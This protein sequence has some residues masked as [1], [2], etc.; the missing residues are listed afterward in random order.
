MK[1]LSPAAWASEALDFSN[2]EDQ[3]YQKFSQ[4]KLQ[5]I[6]TEI[7]SERYRI[8]FHFYQQI[9]IF[10][11][12]SHFL[13]SLC[14]K[15]QGFSVI[16]VFL[17]TFTEL[18]VQQV[19]VLCSKL[20]QVTVLPPVIAKMNMTNFLSCTMYA[21]CYCVPTARP[22]MC[23]LFVIIA[24]TSNDQFYIFMEYKLS[25]CNKEYQ[26]R[27]AISLFLCNGK[28]DILQSRVSRNFC[29]TETSRFFQYFQ[30][31]KH[32]LGCNPSVHHQVTQYLCLLAC[33]I[34]DVKGNLLFKVVAYNL[35][36]SF[37]QDLLSI[38][39]CK[40]KPLCKLS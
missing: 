10:A 32:S 37:P 35:C 3:H 8:S 20:S 22:T 33:R 15:H 26:Y 28:E 7:F 34:E 27:T 29:S 18:Q 38:I 13:V 25:F 19:H 16:I 23:R 39:S 36:I 31:V 24:H 14:Q 17:I 6:R 1:I 4:F 12:I 30:L 9:Q 21:N 40:A 5:A 11:R 2:F